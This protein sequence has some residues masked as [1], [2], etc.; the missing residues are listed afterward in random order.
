VNTGK[1]RTI[2]LRVVIQV[3]FLEH[4]GGAKKL[5]FGL[6]QLGG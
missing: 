3:F 6:S 2:V 4:S 5:I 1:R